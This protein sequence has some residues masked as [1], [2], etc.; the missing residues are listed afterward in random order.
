MERNP[1]NDNEDIEN[2]S[3]VFQVTGSDINSVEI[4]TKDKPVKLEIDWMHQSIA[5]IRILFI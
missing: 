1:E 2:V 5:W 3:H 4:S